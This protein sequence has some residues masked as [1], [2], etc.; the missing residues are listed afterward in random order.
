MR[1]HARHS[2][3]PADDSLNVY[4]REIAA[5]PLLGREQEAELARRGRG[6]DPAAI[7][8]LICSNLRFVVSVAKRYRHQGVPLVDLIDEGNVGLIRAAQKFDERREIKFISYAVWWIRQAIV[9]ALAE[10]SRM[11]RLPLSRVGQIARVGK[12]T[13]ALLQELGRE[14]T[15]REISA[16]LEI[17][18]RDL[19]STMECAP[20]CLSLDAPLAWSDDAYLIDHVPDAASAA[21]DDALSVSGLETAVQ[22]ALTQL[23]GREGIVLRLYFGLGDNEPETLEEIGLRFGVTRERVRQIKERALLRLRKS[24]AHVLSSPVE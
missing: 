23:K 15:R 17:S 13:N 7:Q 10:Q 19:A 24:D 22:T 20:T 14:P 16:D 6:G 3:Q 8:Q 21:P 11:I 9:Q 1:R 18:E 4:L 5:Y 2:R 12:R